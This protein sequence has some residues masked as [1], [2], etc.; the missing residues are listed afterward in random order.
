MRYP[1]TPVPKPRQTRS[2]KWKQRD[3][4]MRYRAFADQVRDAGVKLLP[5]ASIVFFIPMPKSWSNKKREMM[6][7]APHLQTPDTD[8][9][10]KALSDAVYQ[11]DCAMWCYGRV[12]K[13]WSYDGSILIINEGE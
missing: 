6:D 10:I 11:D 4:V 1:I 13:R 3:C 8:N 7:N 12:E 5:G 2:D 9:L